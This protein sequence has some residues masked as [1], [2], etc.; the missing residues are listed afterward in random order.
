[1]KTGVK[2]KA[3]VK[4]HRKLCIVLTVIIVL[5]IAVSVFAGML[6]STVRGLAESMYNQETAQIER[7]TIVESISATGSITSSDSRSIIVNISNVEVASVNVEVGDTVLA[8]DV[9]CTMDAGDVEANLADAKISLNAANSKTS[10]DITSAQR[11]LDEAV[12]AKNIDMQRADSDVSDAYTDYENA[13]DEMDDAEDTLDDAVD[14]T[15]EK[16]AAY[17]SALSAYNLAVGSGTVSEGDAD[18]LKLYSELEQAQSAYIAAQEAESAARSA[19]E[20]AEDKANSLYEVYEDRL[21]S[22]ADTER[23]LDSSVSSKQESLQSSKISASTSGISE[24]QQVKTYE[25]QLDNC[26]VKAPISGVVT[27]LNVEAGDIYNGASIAVIENIEGFEVTAEIDEYDISKIEVGQSVVIKTNGTGDDELDGTVIKIAPRAT[28]G[29]S[30]T[31]TVTISV[32]TPN[33]ALRLDMTAKLSII[34][35]SSENVLSVPYESVQEDTD[36]N[37]YIEVKEE[38]DSDTNNQNT[39]A[40]RRIYVAKGV[41]SDYYIEI[42]SDEITEGME[43]LVPD[44]AS[45]TDADG[46]IMIQ[47]PMGGF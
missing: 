31:Y 19:Y 3:F 12:T 8:G 43:V 15:D 28:G 34:I 23:S 39:D 46:M 1:M 21:E 29:S 16:K 26:T 17:E 40:F 27:E 18:Y 37:Y 4:R 13:V 35:E 9:L 6:R 11:Q 32:D 44:S 14:E 22:R 10:L 38:T 2:V 24:K 41:E 47:G 45:G 20:S 25:E 33:D 42:I 7:R 5:A 30:V 36:G